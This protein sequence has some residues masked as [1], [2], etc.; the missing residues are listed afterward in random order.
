[1]TLS[2]SSPNTLHLCAN[3]RLAMSLKQQA[4]QAQAETASETYRKVA[5]SL[6]ALTIANWWQQWRDSVAFSGLGA[7]D[8]QRLLSDFEAVWWFEQALL[9][10][11]KRSEKQG[12]EIALLNPQQTAKQLY[13][14]WQLS[15]EFLPEGWQEESFLNPENQLYKEVSELYRSQMEKRDWLDSVLLQKASLSLLSRLLNDQPKA[16][17]SLLPERIQ[18]HGFDDYTPFLKQWLEIMTQAG[19]EVIEETPGDK[20]PQSTQL[21]AAQDIRD[22][23]QQAAA[24]AWQSL[25]TLQAVQGKEAIKIGIIAPDMQLYKQ[26]L[27]NALDEYLVLQGV[28]KF[29]L[30]KEDNKLYNLS[31]G[32]PLNSVPLVQ[33]ALLSLQLFLQPHKPYRFAD[34]SQW[35][36]SPYTQG[37]LTKRQQADL[38]LRRLQWSQISLPRLLNECVDYLED[39]ERLLPLILPKS[40]LEALEAQAGVQ[41][42]GKLSQQ[43]FIDAC[44]ETLNRMGWPGSRT[45]SSSEYQQQQAFW[46]ALNSFASM[47]GL[48]RE[49][50]V[51]QWLPLLQSYIAEQLHQPQTKGDRP[52]Q[53]MG[54]LEAGGQQFDALWVL[55]LSDQAWPRA[56]NPNPFIPMHLQREHKLPRADG[57]R[58]LL[59]ARQINQRLQNAT[60]QLVLSY[61]RFS[62]EA[63]LLPSPLLSEFDGKPW[64][65]AEF[66]SLAQKAFNVQN[67][68]RQNDGLWSENSL[69]EWQLDDRGPEVPEGESAP[70]GSGILQAQSKCPLMAFLDYRLGAKYGLQQVEETLQSTN[71]GS[72][73]HRVLELVWDELKTQT[74]LI[75]LSEGEL[76]ELLDR[77]LKTVFDEVHN[78]LS[79][80]LLQLEMARIKQL[81]WDW[82]ELEK[83]RA[84]FAN[85]STEQEVY[86]TL[87]G[88]Q[89]K[90]IVDRI[91]QVDGKAL[92]IDYKSG[93]AS[94]N[95]LLKTPLQAPQLAVYLHALAQIG[96]ESQDKFVTQLSG[97]ICGIGYGLLHSDDGVSFSALSEEGDLLPGR[98]IKVFSKLAENEKSEFYQVQWE[99]LLQSLKEEVETLARQIQQGDARMQFAKET[100]VQ[101][102]QAYLALRLPEVRQQL[103]LQAEET[104]E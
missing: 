10:V 77:H 80:S 70:G 13:Q 84:N 88:I 46:E 53:I 96:Q 22:E 73:L 100:D 5:P 97:Q 51:A 45:L 49:Q 17:K 83:T 86:I 76:S 63:E 36:I 32:Q 91:D 7:V 58:E 31:L 57:H 48:V 40:L 89:F 65:K 78:T 101:Y 12:E 24:W 62:G 94:I 60:E 9:E 56:S 47:Q 54:M 21:F 102:A 90:V 87:A 27:Q 68:D 72:M 18:L 92:I 3:N 75:A 43:A 85:F 50:T 67:A 64:Q 103:K 99:D 52:I 35:L 71:Q 41:Y 16:L 23:A 14:A 2:E 37:D 39:E 25:Q 8:Y 28:Q 79:E 93:K 55:G 98:G 69:I 30:L 20:Q 61:P 4:V 81:C 66:I 19:V 6:Q 82:L 95:D 38:Q 59:Y 74:A 15:N 104:N 1:M 42:S 29:D 26:P 34:W 44:Q 11:L 33:N